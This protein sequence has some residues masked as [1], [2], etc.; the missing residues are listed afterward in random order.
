MEKNK[1]ADRL[2]DSLEGKSK[3]EVERVLA[4]LLENPDYFN[5]IGLTYLLRICG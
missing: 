1:A 5:I 3:E 4:P 2:L